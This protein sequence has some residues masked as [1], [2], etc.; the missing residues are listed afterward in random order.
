[1]A[2]IRTIYS[3]LTT[4]IWDA[5]LEAL[6]SENIVEV[7]S[8]VLNEAHKSIYLIHPGSNKMYLDLKKLYW[9]PNMKVEIATYVSKCLTYSKVVTSPFSRPEKTNFVYALFKNQ[10]NILNK[11][12]VEFVPKQ[13]MIK[14]YQKQ[15][16]RNVF[17]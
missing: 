12:A 3:N 6:K 16:H 10:S 13:N 7:K 11:S 8:I 15:F 14:M 4:Q 2:L 1:M 9:W 5:Q 17:D